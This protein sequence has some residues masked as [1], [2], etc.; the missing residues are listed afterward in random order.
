M[1]FSSQ[2]VDI[3]SVIAR[4]WTIFSNVGS[5]EVEGQFRSV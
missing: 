2:D 5:V 3:S 1:K 4:N